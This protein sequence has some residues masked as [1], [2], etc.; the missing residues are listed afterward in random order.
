MSYSE[1]LYT[2]VCKSAPFMLKGNNTEVDGTMVCSLCGYKH[3]NQLA[4]D[5]L[6][7]LHCIRMQYNSVKIF[8]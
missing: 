5:F 8:Q 7:P 3:Q 2:I 1:V 6:Q 4:T